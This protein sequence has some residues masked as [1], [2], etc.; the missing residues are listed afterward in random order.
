MIMQKGNCNSC[1][2]TF[3]HIKNN[4]SCCDCNNCC[5]YKHKEGKGK[6]SALKEALNINDFPF[7]ENFKE[8]LSSFTKAELEQIKTVVDN[9]LRKTTVSQK[10]SSKPGG[11]DVVV[12][13]SGK[14]GTG[15]K[16]YKTMK[17]K[18]SPEKK[19]RQT[20]ILTIRETTEK[21]S[22]LVARKKPEITSKK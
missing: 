22:A 12:V 17:L 8:A 4:C 14:P 1:N 15:I 19:K 13:T 10:R 18:L 6:D 20:H 2:R 21:K 7:L 16:T 3:M 11:I 5:K 9:E